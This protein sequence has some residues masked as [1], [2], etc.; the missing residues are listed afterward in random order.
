MPSLHESYAEIRTAI[1]SSLGS[2]PLSTHQPGNPFSA[3][4]TALLSRTRAE[5][6]AR[7]IFNS[8]FEAGF[9][10]PEAIAGA[11]VAEL[12]EASSKSVSPKTL[13]PLVQVCK[14]IIEWGGLEALED[15]ATESLRDDL[16]KIPGLGPASVDA[17]LLDG[18]NR[19]VYPVD[20][21]TYR[22]LVRHGW[23]DTSNGYEEARDVVE[24]L[25][26]GDA[27]RLS[28]LATWFSRIGEVYCKASVAKCER[29]PMKP[30]L[31]ESGPIEPDAE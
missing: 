17:V 26:P 22:I 9:G 7:E 30:F 28:E 11:S 21:A 15:I 14:Q 16:L 31:P 27:V 20:R 10:S 4:I 12:V 5:K 6:Q 18:L 13:K 1:K 24:A 3:I 8:L 29:C 23:L 19:P 2:I 25:E